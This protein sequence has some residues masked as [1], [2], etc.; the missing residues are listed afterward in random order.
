VL[1]HGL[2]L[3]AGRRE[4]LMAWVRVPDL[5]VLP[6]VQVYEHVRAT[7]EGGVARFQS[8]GFEAEI[9]FDRDGFVL[10]Y[11]GIGSRV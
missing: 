5:V 1:R 3:R 6:S 8:T 9:S 11:P 4:L 2:H 7:R 10:A